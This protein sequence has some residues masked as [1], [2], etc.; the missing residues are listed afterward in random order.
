MH[1]RHKDQRGSRVVFVAHCLLNANVKVYEYADYPA[2]YLEILQI[3][4]KHKIGLVQLPC[5]ETTHLGLQRWWHVKDQ[6][7][8]PGY[9]TLCRKLAQPVIDQVKTYRQEGVEVVAILGIDGSPTCGMNK[10]VSSENWGGRPQYDEHEDL[11]VPGRGVWF[12]ELAI[13]FEKEG[14]SLPTY[15]GLELERAEKPYEQ[16]LEELEAFLISNIKPLI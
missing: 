16:L 6:Y 4:N 3:L 14:I 1:P 5:P 12:D 9:R 13:C 7:D 8:T 15:Y 2:M 11:L 10:T